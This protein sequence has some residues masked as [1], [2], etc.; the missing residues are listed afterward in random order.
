MSAFLSQTSSATGG[1]A[2]FATVG[3]MVPPGSRPGES[4]WTRCAVFTVSF[5]RAA[6]LCRLNILPGRPCG[7]CRDR[8]YLVRKS[9]ICCAKTDVVCLRPAEGKRE[10]RRGVCCFFILY[11]SERVLRAQT[12]LIDQM[13]TTAVESRTRQRHLGSE[14]SANFK[15]HP[16]EC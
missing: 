13:P 6:I 1:A 9:P 16:S 8:Q 5:S 15:A 7:R 10:A 4:C 12:P 11:I 3:W 2:E 14:H